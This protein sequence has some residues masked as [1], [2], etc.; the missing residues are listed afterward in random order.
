MKLDINFIIQ[1]ILVLCAVAATIIS[2]RT[3]RNS[4]KLSKEE[5]ESKRAFLAPA[6]DPGYIDFSDKESNNFGSLI[7]N[8]KNYG[9]NPSSDIETEVSGYN[10]IDIEGTKE[11]IRTVFS[12]KLNCYN[13]IPYSAD[14][15]IKLSEDRFQDSGKDVIDMLASHYIIA[16]IKYYDNVLN[17]HFNDIFYWRVDE[18][19]K[20]S[21]VTKDIY[22]RLSKL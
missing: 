20:L 7:I 10:R 3:F 13:P 21:E 19:N 12:I 6:S 4:L 17:K 9:I 11:N 8:L 5:R 16:K 18:E 2:A 14:Y 15:F 22:L 1:I